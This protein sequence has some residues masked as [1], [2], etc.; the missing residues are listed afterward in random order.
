M[1]KKFWL[2]FANSLLWMAAGANIARIG[3]KCALSVG[4]LVWLWFIPVFVAFGMMFR[5]TISKNIARIESLP[6]ERQPLYRCMSLKGY[7]II[8][9]MM[10]LGIFLRRIG[11]IPEGFFSFFYTGLG[12]ALA[13]S[14]LYGL[15]LKLK[16]K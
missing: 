11:G 1:V 3:I 14:G 4:S 7:L 12:S 10:S 16:L 9:F 13:L 5:R 2:V 15:Y 6:G 8:A